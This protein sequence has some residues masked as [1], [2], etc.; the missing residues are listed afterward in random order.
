V[1]TGVSATP[2]VLWPPNQKMIDVLVN[3]NVAAPC[4]EPPACLLQVASNEPVTGPGFGDTSPDWVVVDNHH[5]QLRAERSGS[6]S[7]RV[8]TITISCTDTRGN[9]AAMNTTVTVPHSL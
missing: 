1:I 3:Y 6:G 5:V 7:G 9:S 4:G 2:A 8:Y